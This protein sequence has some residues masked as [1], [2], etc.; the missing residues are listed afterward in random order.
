MLKMKKLAWVMMGALCLSSTAFAQE[1]E[2][3]WEESSWEES[4]WGESDESSAQSTEK[5]PQV[6]FVNTC[7]NRNELRAKTKK[8]LSPYRYCSSKVTTITFKKY[9]HKR[10]VIVPVY[11]DQA[12]LVSFNTEGLGEEIVIKVFDQPATKK[13]RNLLF[14]SQPGE[15]N[16][17][18]EL[19]ADYKSGKLYIEY[20]VPPGGDEGITAK[21]CVIFMMGYLD[22]EFMD[23]K[24]ETETAQK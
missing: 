23:L 11:Y 19:P 9:P 15:K 22:E 21:G 13:K 6:N 10:E 17:L 20:I 3:S 8:S 16:S 14:Q 7:S 18:L 4:S 24:K 1:E 5:K 12:H 2:E